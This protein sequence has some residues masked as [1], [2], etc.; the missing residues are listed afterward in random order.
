[1]ARYDSCPKAPDYQHVTNREIQ[2]WEEIVNKQQQRIGELESTL[3][4]IKERVEK[5]LGSDKNLPGAGQ[6]VGGGS[7]SG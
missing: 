4:Q 7:V 3:K 6:D 5:I 2:C 1:M